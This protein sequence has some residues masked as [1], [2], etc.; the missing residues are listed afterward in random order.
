MFFPCGWSGMLKPS[1]MVHGAEI[2]PAAGSFI[3]R[4]RELEARTP[5]C[6]F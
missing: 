1:V 5:A 2:D 6:T 3:F 4:H